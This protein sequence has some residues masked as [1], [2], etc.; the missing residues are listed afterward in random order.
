MNSILEEPILLTKENDFLGT[1]EKSKAI[2]EFIENNDIL[3]ESNN[4]IAIYGEWGSGKSSVLKTSSDMLNL[5]Q[6]HKIWIDMWKEESDYTNLSIKILNSVLIS[7]NINKQ[8]KKDLLKSFLILGK[9]LKINAGIISYDMKPAIEQLEIELENSQK[10][11]NFIS[12]FQEQIDTY[13]KKTGKKVI[14]FLDDLDRC[15]S[16]NML[17]IIYNI[18]LLMS[19]RN[20]IFVFGIDKKAVTL[21]LKNRYN[22]EENKADSFLDK[23]FPISFNLPHNF[24]NNKID[25]LAN[26]ISE[27]FNEEQINNVKEFFEDLNFT[28]P[29]RLIK[30]INRYKIIENELTRKLLLDNSNEW[31]IML[32]LFLIIEHEFNIDNYLEMLK[33]NKKQLLGNVIKLDL[34][35]ASVDSGFPRNSIEYEEY[36]IYLKF[37]KKE[38]KEN[39]KGEMEEKFCDAY[40]EAELYEYFCNPNDVVKDI[41]VSELNWRLYVQIKFENWM[42]SFKNSTNK[43][44]IYFFDK[45]RHEFITCLQEKEDEKIYDSF[46][47]QLKELV[48]EIDLLL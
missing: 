22:N 18:K 36:P 39:E 24:T 15:D 40:C 4:M 34:A 25:I 32:I 45:Y 1:L 10:T 42:G 14:V 23:I 46:T 9:G 21:A 37:R 11:E 41:R 33:D 27:K 26:K 30:V 3:L 16:D 2:K 20:I 48:Y 35:S 31:N 44:F 17:N 5:E 12:S 6:Y 47:K 19:V 13:Y 43:R 8:T 7:L 38:M 29:R 28:N